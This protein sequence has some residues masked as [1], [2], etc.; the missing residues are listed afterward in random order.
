MVIGVQVTSYAEICS[1]FV[2]GNKIHIIL[3]QYL[4]SLSKGCTLK[5]LRRVC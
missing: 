3:V 1:E 2:R 5:F 4:Y